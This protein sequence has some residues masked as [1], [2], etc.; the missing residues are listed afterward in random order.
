MNQLTVLIPC[1]NEIENL[2]ECLASVRPVADEILIADSGSQDGTLDLIQRQ[3]DCRLIQRQYIH[4]GDFKN[5]AI[6]KAR[7][8]RVLVID[9]DELTSW[10]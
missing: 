1:K 8:Q 9:A 5:W 10:N 3:P 2:E 7:H 4:S 6:P